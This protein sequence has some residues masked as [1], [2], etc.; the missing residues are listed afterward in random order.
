MFP[1]VIAIRVGYIAAHPFIPALEPKLPTKLAIPSSTP[2]F[3]LNVSIVTGRV[4][5]LDLEVKAKIK[6]S[7]TFFKYL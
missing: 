1:K 5:K 4:L 3:L 6:G 2:T 7:I